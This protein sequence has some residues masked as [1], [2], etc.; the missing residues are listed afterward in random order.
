MNFGRRRNDLKR[1]EEKGMKK[2]KLI[3]EGEEK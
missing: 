1:R 3:Q 2:K